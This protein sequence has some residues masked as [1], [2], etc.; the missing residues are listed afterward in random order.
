MWLG[1]PYYY[2][3]ETLWAHRNPPLGKLAWVT[4]QYTISL[5]YSWLPRYIQ[6]NLN[7][8]D[9]NLLTALFVML[10]TI[11]V[12]LLILIWAFLWMLI[13]N[14]FWSFFCTYLNWF[15]TAYMATLVNINFF[16]RLHS[17]QFDVSG[18]SLF[19]L[20]I[21][22]IQKRFSTTFLPEF[23]VLH[24]TKSSTCVTRTSSRD[25]SLLFHWNIAWGKRYFLTPI[26]NS[27]FS[28]LFYH[29]PYA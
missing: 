24:Y 29:S 5:R 2:V 20:L 18:G 17:I 13:I 3:T 28:T 27:S 25:T 16:I 22:M 8:E 10:S 11:T 9:C 12:N 4:A 21:W 26:F 23:R 19:L 15:Q 1:Q 7:V 6:T 14:L